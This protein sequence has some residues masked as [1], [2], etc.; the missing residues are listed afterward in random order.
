MAGVRPGA[1]GRASARCA[2]TAAPPPG[3]SDMNWGEQADGEPQL[4]AGWHDA[5]LELRPGDPG[6]TYDPRANPVRGRLSNAP[7]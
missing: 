6:L 4:P 3:D 2:Q 5:W 1:R 7:W